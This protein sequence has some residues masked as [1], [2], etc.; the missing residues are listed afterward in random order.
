ME[1]RSILK[2]DDN[3]INRIAA[4]EIL[5]RPGN[6]LKEML[7]NSIDAKATRIQITVVNG[8][9]KLLQDNGCGIRK[10]DFPILCER[11]TTS[12]LR[13]YDD[14]STMSTFGFRG[15]ALASI[16]H[17]AHLT[18]TSK[19]STEQCA[20]KAAYLDGVLVGDIKPI[21]GNQG[22]LIS[23]EDI[24]YNMPLRKNTLNSP[25]AE[26]TIISDLIGKYSINNPQVGFSLKKHGE[27]NNIVTQPNSTSIDNIRIHYGNTVAKE[28]LEFE[29]ENRSFKFSIKGHI[30]NVNYSVKNMEFI[31]FINDRLVM[32][33]NLRKS[34]DDV[35]S[36]YLPK[37]MHPFLYLSMQ[38]EPRNV[39]VNVHPTKHEVHLLD[40]EKIVEIVTEAISAKLLGSNNSRV[41]YAQ[42]LLPGA[43]VVENSNGNSSINNTTAHDKTMVRTDHKEQKLEAFF[44]PSTSTSVNTANQSVAAADS[45]Q[46]VMRQVAQYRGEGFMNLVSAP[47]PTRKLDENSLSSFNKRLIP[48]NLMS[49]ILLQ[50]ELENVCDDVLREV[51]A[52][53]FFVGCISPK[54]SLFQHGNKLFL[55]NTEMVM[56]ELC[57]EFLIFHFHNFDVYRFET[58]LSIYELA[59]IAL[60]LPETGWHEIDGEKAVLAESAVSILQSK[61]KVLSEFFAMEIDDCGNL[62]TIP[63]LIDKYLPNLSGLPMLILRIAAEV[64][65]DKE[66]ECFGNFAR[67]MSRFYG[68]MYPDENWEHVHTHILY[69]AIK[70]YFCPSNKFRGNGSIVQLACLPSLYKVFERC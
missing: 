28:L 21:A 37:S 46:P 34:I 58:P 61:A 47:G 44:G 17:V 66:E 39:D 62:L 8:G 10:E 11:F 50:T 43:S 13:T 25:Q 48:D 51:F 55:C 15:E 29:M 70:D 41:F 27:N 32:V 24:F 3:V 1:P 69:P 65:W 52:N 57:F 26:Y 9:I 14:L 2:L 49:I 63:I 38:V 60:D 45:N 54:L 33:P 31:I 18:I 16:S 40:E 68:K 36:M 6:A 19:T 35:Y 5:Q 22:T 23:V 20:Y 64:E 12:K 59:M 30:S 4:G 42:T 7:E 67:E 53:H 56:Q